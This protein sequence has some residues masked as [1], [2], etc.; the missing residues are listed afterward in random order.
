MN[1]IAKL[2]KAKTIDFTQVLI[3]YYKAIGLNE[4]TAVIVAKLYYLA[5]ENDNFFAIE[6]KYN[7]LSM[8][9]YNND[10]TDYIENCE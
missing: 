5:E 1:N 7:K 2:I 10:T 6:A 4:T 9:L 8:E 3:K